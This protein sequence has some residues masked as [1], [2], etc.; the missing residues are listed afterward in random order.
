MSAAGEFAL[1]PLLFTLPE[2]PI[3]VLLLAC[4]LIVIRLHLRNADLCGCAGTALK[5]LA[6]ANAGPVDDPAGLCRRLGTLPRW[7]SLYVAG[8]AVLQAV[9]A[10][11]PVVPL[12]QPYPFLPLIAISAY[13]AMGVILVW[14][15]LNVLSWR[16]PPPFAAG[17]A[18]KAAKLASKKRD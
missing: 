18:T 3:K 15:W 12:L 14:A 10:L 2:L 13:C 9:D 17:S 16:L 8:M 5:H 6:F 1:L 11:A 4:H 7:A